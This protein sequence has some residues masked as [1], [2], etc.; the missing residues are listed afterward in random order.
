VSTGAVL[1]Y[2]NI[3]LTLRSNEGKLEENSFKFLSS[4]LK[5]EASIKKMEV[6]ERSGKS[7]NNVYVAN[8]TLTWGQVCGGLCGSGFTRNKVVVMS[9]SG[10]ILEMFLDDPANNSSWIA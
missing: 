5:Y 9:P 1:Y 8:M 2:Y 6:Y 3:S 10:E 4:N 7:F